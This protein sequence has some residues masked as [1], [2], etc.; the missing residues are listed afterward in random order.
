MKKLKYQTKFLL[1][2]TGIM[3]LLI[4]GISGWFYRTVINEMH[5]RERSDF[6]I[7]AEKTASQL[8]NLYY[9]MD[10]TAL[11]IAANPNIVGIFQAL[12]VNSSGN[13]FTEHPL[14]KND[15]KKLL[16]SYNF[17]SNGH[18]RICLYNRYDD[19][20]CTANRAVTDEGIIRFFESGD[21]LKVKEYFSQADRY[22]YYRQPTPDI[23]AYGEQEEPAYFSVVREIKDYYSESTRWG[24]IEVQESTEK[25]DS[26]F[27]DLGEGVRI[28]VVN[29]DGEKFYEILSGEIEWKNSDLNKESIQLEN[30]PYQVIFYKNPA[31]FRQSLKQFYLAF[32]VVTAIVFGM[33]VLLERILIR[34][35]SKPLINLNRS[36]KSVTVDNLHVDIAEKDSDDIVIRLE[37][38]FNTMLEKLNDSMKKQVLAKTNEVKSHYFALQSQMNPHFIHNILAIVSMESQLDGNEKIPDICRRLG[39]ILRYNSEMGD[40]YST[41]GMECEIASDYME[42]MKVRYEDAFEFSVDIEP[43]TVEL[44]IPK[45]VVQPLCENCFQH[46]LKYVDHVWKIQIHAWIEG[47]NWFLS[48][49]DNG[50]GFSEEFLHEFEK[51]KATLY[52]KDVKDILEN[53][54]IGGLCIP[55]IYTRMRI[56]YGDGF[57]FKMYNDN[58]AVVL[59]GGGINDKGADCGR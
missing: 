6:R 50:N 59:L 45:L 53:I 16:E 30:A 26:I 21:Y 17:K 51:K 8:D 36:L 10:R 41:V 35:L 14:E 5:S 39:K 32:A 23:L 55:N 18:A 27:S 28:E 37:D 29:A 57:C 19:F 46:G 34:H 7:I 12:P 40:G 42:L 4:I 47:K 9:E 11:Q 2:H 58:G 15:I 43:S 3:V 13:Y 38:S 24:Y 1:Y 25:I 33:A 22:I 54:S 31:E 20:V 49:R 44:A 48:V 52:D 56:E